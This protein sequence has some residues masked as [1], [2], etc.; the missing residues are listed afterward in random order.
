[1]ATGGGRLGRLAATS[2]V[3]ALAVGAEAAF[4]P[5]REE[6]GTTGSA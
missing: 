4:V 5:A 1:M 3:A 2:A 6:A